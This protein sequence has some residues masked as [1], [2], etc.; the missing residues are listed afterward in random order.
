MV[1]NKVRFICG[2]GT[3][4]LHYCRICGVPYLSLNEAERCE[5][6]HTDHLGEGAKTIPHG[7]ALDIKHR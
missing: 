4:P 7:D 1:V 3:V 2:M 5:Q 6:A